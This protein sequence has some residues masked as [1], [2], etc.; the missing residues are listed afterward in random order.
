MGVERGKEEARHRTEKQLRAQV[1][2]C[3]LRP[4]EMHV[5]GFTS[6]S[7]REGKSQAF[8]LKRDGSVQRWQSLW[9]G[10]LHMSVS[11][12]LGLLDSI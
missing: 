11:K 2:N 5:R 12:I 4:Q 9:L 8:Q 10:V 1:L 3:Q 7:H 6:K